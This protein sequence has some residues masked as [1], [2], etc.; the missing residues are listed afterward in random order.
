MY[1]IKIDLLSYFYTQFAWHL[2]INTSF[3]QTKW[4]GTYYLNERI[5]PREEKKERKMRK[6]RNKSKEGKREEKLYQAPLW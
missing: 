1:G 3:F 5:Q 6:K 2:K 4:R